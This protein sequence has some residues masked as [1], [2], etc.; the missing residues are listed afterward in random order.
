MDK[1]EG[2]LSKDSFIRARFFGG[3]G[4][5]L[6]FELPCCGPC[7]CS[8][9]GNCITFRE[10]IKMGVSEVVV[11]ILLT[12]CAAA[13]QR[14]WFACMA[15]ILWAHLALLLVAACHMQDARDV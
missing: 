5:R 12:G 8:A 9:F 10:Y 1:G 7:M 11:V 14:T 2:W 15:L 3:Y 6:I 4:V 13:A